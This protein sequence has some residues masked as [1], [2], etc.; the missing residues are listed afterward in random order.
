MRK[1]YLYETNMHMIYNIFVGQTNKQLQDNAESDANFQAFNTGQY[2]IGYLMIL[3]KLFFSN[4]Y[5]QHP[6]RSLCLANRRLHNTI[7][8]TNENTTNYV[9]SFSNA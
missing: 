3:N 1:K 4:K 8:Y 9:V 6:I 5:E 7:Q 2:P